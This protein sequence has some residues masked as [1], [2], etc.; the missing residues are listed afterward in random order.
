MSAGSGILVH[1][2]RGLFK[3]RIV[4]EAAQLAGI[5]VLQPELKIRDLE[6]EPAVIKSLFKKAESW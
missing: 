2:G 6:D 1:G 4:A 3:H 5:H